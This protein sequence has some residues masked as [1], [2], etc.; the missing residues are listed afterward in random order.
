MSYAGR[1][2]DKS[3][4]KMVA[5]ESPYEAINDTIDKNLIVSVAELFDKYLEW[6]VKYLPPVS[7][8]NSVHV[9]S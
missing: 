9:D 1:V 6:A 5:C 7:P 8:E 4:N 2:Y 3:L